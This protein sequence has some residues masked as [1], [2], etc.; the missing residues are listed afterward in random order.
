[1]QVLVSLLCFN[2]TLGTTCL[3]LFFSESVYVSK[4]YEQGKK[5]NRTKGNIEPQHILLI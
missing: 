5:P 3:F 4:E 1:M 2:I